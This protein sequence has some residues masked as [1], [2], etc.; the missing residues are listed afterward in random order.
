MKYH[1]DLYIKCDVL[2]LADV[3]EKFR[4]NSLKNY[5]LCQSHFLRAPGLSWDATLEMIKIDLELILDPD[6]YIFF[7]K[8]TRGGLSYISNRYTKANNKN[9]KSYDLRQESKYIIYLDANN[10][11]G[12]AMSKFLPTNWLKWIDPKRFDLNKY[13]INNSKGCVLEVDLKY[14]KELRELHNDYPLAPDK[15]E[16]KREMLF[17]YQLKIADLCNIPTG[18]VKKLVANIFA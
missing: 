9:L 3:F 8:G 12:Y 2:L 10:S 17:E 4:N 1:H 16:V 11:Y 5:E 13:A 15:I 18:N 7:E 6:R 14:P